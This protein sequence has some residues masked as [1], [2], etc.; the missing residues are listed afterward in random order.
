MNTIVTPD[1]KKLRLYL[2]II[3][4]KICLPWVRH[5]M[6]KSV[7]NELESPEDAV[8]HSGVCVEC[9]KSFTKMWKSTVVCD[10][11]ECIKQCGGKV[12][13]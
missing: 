12:R 7:W 5:E 11:C 13:C 9:K 1:N 8:E 6:S 4:K 2:R 3:H 10:A